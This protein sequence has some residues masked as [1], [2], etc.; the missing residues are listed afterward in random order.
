MKICIECGRELF[1]YDELCDRC[2]SN[3][4]IIEKEYRNIIEELKNTNVLKRNKLLQDSNYKKIYDR[5]QQPKN[6]ISKPVILQNKQTVESDEEYWERINKHTINRPNKN[7]PVVECPYCHS[8][9]TKRISAMNRVVST[10][11]FGFGSK[12]IGKQYHCNKCKSDF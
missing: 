9:D 12:K 10:G 8:T 2:N 6:Q 5:M 4:I 3:N 7:N 1:D 11:L